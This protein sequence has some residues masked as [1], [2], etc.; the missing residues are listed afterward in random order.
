MNQ[1]NER[2]KKVLYLPTGA[3]CCLL[4]IKSK[5]RAVSGGM[6]ASNPNATYFYANKIVTESEHKNDYE[7]AKLLQLT[8]IQS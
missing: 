4:S 2:K 5:E 1:L 7:Q 8:N 6:D 3:S